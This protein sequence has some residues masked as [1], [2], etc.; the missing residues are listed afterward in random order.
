M[1]SNNWKDFAELV[2]IAAIVASLVFVGVQLQ[3]D[4]EIAE[5]QIHLGATANVAAITQS[6]ADN[7]SVWRRGLVGEDLTPDERATFNA[8]ARAIYQRHFGLYNRGLRLNLAPPEVV[9]RRFAF[10]AYQY[11]GLRQY[12]ATKFAEDESLRD[13]YNRSGN[14][15]GTF[16]AP[17]A[18]GNARDFNQQL[19]DEIE[20]LD[21]L[22]P[23]VADMTYMPL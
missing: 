14:T 7:Q 12:L 16:S 2:G 20:Q 1:R 5:A 23:N 21:E 15:R 10:F 11:K 4:Q 6:I 19:A 17:R 22:Q 18:E 9:V 13:I 8:I 3:Q